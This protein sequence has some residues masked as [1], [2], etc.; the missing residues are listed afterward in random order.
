LFDAA[1]TR[2]LPNVTNSEM[3]PEEQNIEPCSA[4]Y[5]RRIKTDTNVA[6]E[7]LHTTS[8]RSLDI[9]NALVTEH[10]GSTP[11]IS[12]SAVERDQ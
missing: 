11:L 4:G 12:K 1:F 6:R 7:D 8:Q 2:R 9:T 3:K 5:H 10:E